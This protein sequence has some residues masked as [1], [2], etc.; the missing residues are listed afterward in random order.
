[1]KPSRH[2]VR[3]NYSLIIH[4]AS[5][6]IVRMYSICLINF[7]V[8]NT[9]KRGSFYV[10][11]VIKIFVCFIVWSYDILIR[12]QGQ[13]NVKMDIH[14]QIRVT[15]RATNLHGLRINMNIVRSVIVSRKRP[16]IHAVNLPGMRC[17]LVVDEILRLEQK[18]CHD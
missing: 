8:K 18:T 6:N 12:C 3:N 1:M 16:V 15:F 17:M 9:K 7:W 4:N 13:Q 11:Q 2:I 10:V 5:Q 14:L